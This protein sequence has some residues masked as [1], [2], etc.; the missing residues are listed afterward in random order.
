MRH[1]LIRGL[2]L[3]LVAQTTAMPF[4]EPHFVRHLQAQEPESVKTLRLP[5]LYTTETDEAVSEALA[6]LARQQ[7]DNGAFGS[8]AQYKGNVA[9]TSLCGMALIASGSTPKAGPYRDHVRKTVGYILEAAQPNGL[10]ID[11]SSKSKGPMYGHGFATLFLAETF[12]MSKRQD[13]REKLMK[14]VNVIVQ[15]Q[16]A[17]GG[18][19]YFIDSKDADVSVTVCQLVALRAAKNAGMFVPKTTVDRAVAYLKSAQNPD[20]GFQYQRQEK[21]TS[22]FPRSAAAIV[23]LNG[24]GIYEGREIEDGLKYVMKFLPHGR[25][26]AQQQY[27]FYGQYYAGQAMWQAGGNYWKAWYPAVRE[28]LLATRNEQGVW[29]NTNFGDEYATAMACLVLQIPKNYLPIF[30]R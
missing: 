1:P 22:E 10:I 20:G 26:S 17:E 18:W 7:N 23:A 21:P 28:Q 11:D 4:A 14:A 16:T 24:A 15:T 25:K 12:G 27:Y 13:L 8:L 29:S 9:I 6:W 30:D 19:R 2:I 5:E 3:I